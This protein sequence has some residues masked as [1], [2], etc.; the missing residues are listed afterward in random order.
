M[1]IPKPHRELGVLELLG[2]AAA[3][4]LVAAVLS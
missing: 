4:V 2:I 3:A 1:R